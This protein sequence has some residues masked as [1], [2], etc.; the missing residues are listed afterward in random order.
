MRGFL[1]AVDLSPPNGAKAG[2][3]LSR[4]ESLV[5][6][7]MDEVD[8]TIEFNKG[9]KEANLTEIAFCISHLI[10]ASISSK[11]LT[12]L[13]G[14][15]NF[16][17]LKAE[18]L[19]KSKRDNSLM[20]IVNGLFAS[21]KLNAD[22]ALELL[23]QYVERIRSAESPR[24]TESTEHA[25]RSHESQLPKGYQPNDL[26][27]VG[28]LLRIAAAVDLTL[29]REIAASVKIEIFAKYATNEASLGRLAVFLL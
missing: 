6:Q 12:L 3:G 25:F 22:L 4:R 15:E 19:Q 29:A 5:R 7:M 27:D 8:L 14:F 26:V 16:A 1:A 23:H 18:I 2:A 17:S 21:A 9:C 28:S 20:H 10:N 11:D 13:L 24:S